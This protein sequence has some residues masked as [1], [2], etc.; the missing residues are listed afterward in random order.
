MWYYLLFFF[1]TVGAKLV[2]ALVMIY[3]L[4][5]NDRLC[6]E[7]DSETFLLGGNRWARLRTRLFLG[8]VRWRWCPR[9]GWEGMSRRVVDAPPAAEVRAGSPIRGGR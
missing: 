1:V 9:C 6:A 7:C 8:R 2:M 5:P 3:Y 4:L